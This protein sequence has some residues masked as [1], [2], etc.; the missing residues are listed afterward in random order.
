MFSQEPITVKYVGNEFEIMISKDAADDFKVILTNRTNKDQTIRKTIK[1]DVVI[2]DFVKEVKSAISP[3][4]IVNHVYEYPKENILTIPFANTT[5]YATLKQDLMTLPETEFINLMAPQIVYKKNGSTLASYI[6]DITT[7][8]KPFLTDNNIYNFK[9]NTGTAVELSTPTTSI[10]VSSDEAAF[11]R[12]FYNQEKTDD[13]LITYLFPENVYNNL[14]S[15]KNLVKVL[16]EIF[17]KLNGENEYIFIQNFAYSKTYEVSI[18]PN[19][20]DKYFNLQVCIISPRECKTAPKMQYGIEFKEFEKLFKAFMDS[21]FGESLALDSYVTHQLYDQCKI[22]SNKAIREEAKKEFIDTIEALTRQIE[23]L[24]PKFSGLLQ[25][26]K[27][28]KVYQFSSGKYSAVQNVEFQPEYATVRFF[29]NKAK[30]LIIVGKYKNQ[31]KPEQ[32][33]EFV[34]MNFQYSIPLRGFNNSTQYVRISPNDQDAEGYYLRYNDVFH[35][36][37]SESSYSYSARNNEYRI[38]A[39]KSAKIVQRRLADYFTAVIFS[40]FLGLNSDSSNSL[41]QAE[42]RLKAPLWINNWRYVSFFSSIRADLNASIYN[43]F[44]DNSRFITPVNAPQGLVSAELDTLRINNFDYV[45][46]NNVNAFI[47]I[48]LVNVELKGLSS[49]LSFGYGMRYYR[50]GVK[51]T[52]ESEGGD[53]ERTYQLNALSH[54]VSTNLEIRPQLNFGADLN[55]GFNWINGR[56]SLGD[57]PIKYN[58][59]NRREDRIVA[60]VLLNVYSMIDPDTSN[61]GIFARIGGFYHLGAK[62]FYPQIMVGYATN[63]TSFVNKFKKE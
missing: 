18:K 37:P 20:K 26:N 56:G 24:K 30:E 34:V 23:N 51:Y 58:E 15:D 62:D 33:P 53:Q 48:D 13:A 61:D 31:D 32:N 4:L 2:T 9:K 17:L 22:Y 10:Q 43:G 54:E 44:D 25:V 60:R 28:V 41:L 21:N 7:N 38:E 8:Q 40:D 12:A 6:S 63:L 39:G 46:F 59:D 29:N 36:Y 35:Y 19:N 1:N 27:S 3:P 42:G 16:E 47:G 50:A 14:I 57:I 52:I 55:I 49:E 5:D 45:K 11:L